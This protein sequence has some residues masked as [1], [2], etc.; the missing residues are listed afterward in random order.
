[1]NMLL[2]PVI[3]C[4]DQW[5]KKRAEITLKD[6]ERVYCLKEKASLKL[7]YNRGAFLGLLKETP[8]LL[9]LLTLV[10]LGGL[11]VLGLPYW[12]S[13]NKRMTATGLALIFAGAAGNYTDRVL[14]GK[15]VDFL[16]FAPRHKVH[17][18]LA[19]FAIFLG[20]GLMVIGEVFGQ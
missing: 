4:L 16:A 15:V 8:T 5:T 2:I 10:C 20:A 18:N 3:W 6:R 19:D 17:F 12:L 9:N 11:L 13:G 14:K 1:M 7:V